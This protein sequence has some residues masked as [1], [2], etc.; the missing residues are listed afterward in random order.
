MGIDNKIGLKYGHLIVLSVDEEKPKKNPYKYYI[1]QCSCGEIII[2][3]G[4]TLQPYKNMYCGR[5]ECI[6]KP[7]KKYLSGKNSSHQLYKRYN[8]MM[9]RCYKEKHK[10]YQGYGSRG[11]VVC[12]EWKNNYPNFFNWA[13]NNGWKYGLSLDRKDPDK[14]YT[15]ENCQWITVSEN[16]ASGRKVKFSKSLEKDVISLREQKLNNKEIANKLDVT[17]CQVQNVITRLGIGRHKRAGEELINF[18]KQVSDLRNKGMSQREI[19]KYLN[20]S[21]STIKESYR[22]ALGGRKERRKE[23]RKEVIA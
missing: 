22:R 13:I 8:A 18:D 10:T 4:L 6:Y 5:K 19:V 21:L 16:C 17:P 9:T 3:N 11:I 20:L 1:C 15:P 2:R 23:R 12:D 14:N 7:N